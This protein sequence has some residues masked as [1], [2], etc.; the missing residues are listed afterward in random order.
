MVLHDVALQEFFAY[1]YRWVWGDK[2]G[3]L[4]KMAHYYGEDARRDGDLFW[5]DRLKIDYLVERY[6]FTQVALEQGLAAI[7]HN[8]QAIPA[9]MSDTCGIIPLPL[10][11]VAH[12]WPDASDR[13]TRTDPLRLVIFGYISRNRR[14]EAVL[15]ALARYP[16]ALQL[17]M[18][19][20]Y[21]DPE[22]IRGLI[23]SLRLEDRV[24]LRGFVPEA[25]LDAALEQAHLAFNLRFPTMGESSGSQLRI[26]DHSLASLVTPVG[27]YARLPKDSVGFA[28]ADHE[29]EDIHAHLDRLRA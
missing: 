3:Y 25:E 2:E 19:G 13:W 17:D 10:P 1:C 12:Q 18:Y 21:W 27:W 9:D 26:W 7:V 14:M 22:H 20:Q 11:Y 28:R 5:Q 8:G 23:R 6:P 4:A 24:R 16:H 29:V 15:D